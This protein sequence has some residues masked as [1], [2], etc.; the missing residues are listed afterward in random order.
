MSGDFRLLRQW[1]EHC[2]ALAPPV[3]EEWIERS[4][5]DAALRAELRAMLAADA[6]TTGFF[7]RDPVDHLPELAAA[8]V[9]AAVGKVY[10]AYRLVRLLGH[11]GQAEVYLADRATQDFS[12][13]VAVKL[14]RRSFVDD[15]D[16]RRFRRERDILARFAHRGIARL[17][18]GGVGQDGQPF[19][20]MDYVD[21]MEIDAWCRDHGPDLADRLRLFVELCE[22]VAAAHRALIV[23]R[24][25]KPSNILVTHERTIKVLDFGI[26]AL[27]DED[28]STRTAQPMLTPGYGAPEQRA[29]LR[30]TPA[31]DV[32]AL[33]AMLRELLTGAPPP[34]AMDAAASTW[35]TEVPRELRWIV[36]KAGAQDPDARYRDAAELLEDVQ[37]YRAQRPVRAGPPSAWYRTRKFI[38]RHRGGVSVTLALTLATFASLAIALWQAQA[39]K[40]QARAAEATRDFLV[41]VF[42]TAEEDLPADQLPTPAVLAKIAVEKLRENPALPEN[43]RAKYLA[44]L[45]EISAWSNAS[46]Q[47]IAL[48]DESLRLTGPDAGEP[49]RERLRME[50]FRAM[51][52][53]DSGDAPAAERALAPRL[54]ALRAAADAVA[55]DGLDQ[56]A[57]A[58]LY[59]GRAQEAFDTTLE[60][61]RIAARVFAPDT[62]RALG[63]EF[64]IAA[65]A[66]G[67][68]KT[69][70]AAAGFQHALAEWRKLGFPQNQEY[71]TSLANYGIALRTLGRPREAEAAFVEALPLMRRIHPK[72]HDTLAGTMQMVARLMYDRGEREQAATLREQAIDMLRQLH[73]EVHPA[74]VRATGDR[75]AQALQEFRYG[76]AE[77]IARDALALCA[78]E[79]L[80]ESPE[81][82][83]S[84]GYLA[85]ALLRQGRFEEANSL[86]QQTLLDSQRLLGPNYARRPEYA[87]R[88]RDAADTTLARDNAAQALRYA[89]QSLAILTTAGTDKSVESIGLH[90]TRAQCLLSLARHDDAD[91]ELTLAR[92]LLQDLAPGLQA[93]VFRAWVVQAQLDTALERPDAARQA[94]RAALALNP[95][96]QAL[97]AALL[98]ELETLAR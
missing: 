15:A 48:L 13:Q 2:I 27:L 73:G 28:D 12:Q 89:D 4:V 53:I 68:G 39:A 10:G 21:G 80:S 36:D 5:G 81:C 75:A 24:D 70:E 37:A 64:S 45:G 44:L 63:R 76:D 38:A 74:Y 22:I 8:T 59:Q 82:L 51:A 78:H 23:H 50:V 32:Y 33:G 9:G 31:T 43:L 92:T 71:T 34:R 87:A 61:N 94:A 26:A 42:M 17:I 14:L 77:R 57:R 49:T 18:D 97:P 19:L 25:L 56:Y 72:G 85:M 86:A 1:F 41:S 16:L 11:G 47:A 69:R 62:P 91:S 6:R 55:V 58:L 88:L 52:L 65:K 96:P 95:P 98:R 40:E 35:P 60:S 20:V 7:A 93:S 67:L 79:Q 90:L 54:A 83:S 29:G 66:L 30:A 84:R 3:R 46:E